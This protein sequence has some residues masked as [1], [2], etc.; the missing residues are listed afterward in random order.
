MKLKDLREL[1]SKPQAPELGP[2]RRCE[3]GAACLVIPSFVAHEAAR[4]PNVVPA[5]T[6]CACIEIGDSEP[7]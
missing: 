7:A 2:V 1:Y 4:P 6:A 3:C 5:H